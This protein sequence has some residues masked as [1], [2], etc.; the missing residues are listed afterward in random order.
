[1][2]GER[3]LL[4]NEFY[5]TPLWTKLSSLVHKRFGKT[6]SLQTI[7]DV[8]SLDPEL[9]VH[10][11]HNGHLIVP[12]LRGRTSVESDFIHLGAAVVHQGASLA[13]K[14]QVAVS[15]LV[16]MVL[17][18]ALE[19]LVPGQQDATAS[20]IPASGYTAS[21]MSPLLYLY[22]ES[23]YVIHRVAVQ[24]HQVLGSWAFLKYE[25][26]RDQIKK[27]SDLCE[28]GPC[29]ILIGD[30]GDLTEDEELLIRD[31]FDQANKTQDPFILV[32]GSASIGPSHILHQV[33]LSHRLQVDALPNNYQVLRETLE[34]LFDV[35]S[36]D[37]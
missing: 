12:V 33:L 15:D 35:R 5:R 4:S 23:P 10:S 19:Q 9:D 6:L 34:L 22:S 24:I 13:L 2:I 16:R 31:Y 36:A 26:I 1:M 18:P 17:A 30:V 27:V 37:S 11:I 14:D 7:V 29:T 3:A 32:G 20:S 28:L 21:L 8:T 25:D